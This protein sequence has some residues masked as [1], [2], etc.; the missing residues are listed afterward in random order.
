MLKQLGVLT[1][2]NN[3]TANECPLN[4]KLEWCQNWIKGSFQSAHT[5]GMVD[6]GKYDNYL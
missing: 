3:K 6:E 1:C 2:E 4:I 5:R